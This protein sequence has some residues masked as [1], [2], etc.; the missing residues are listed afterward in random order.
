MALFRREMIG[1]GEL[2]RHVAVDQHPECRIGEQDVLRGEAVARDRRREVINRRAEQR[3]IG[4]RQL[5]RG[6]VERRRMVE[7][8]RRLAY[9]RG[10]EI[11]LGGILGGG[12]AG[13]E[14]QGEGGKR[15]TADH[16]RRLRRQR[17]A[18][19][20]CP[21]FARFASAILRSP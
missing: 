20:G 1:F 21:A 15:E 16:A 12:W 3:H 18:I 8:I 4:L 14:Q 6:I 2:R 17:Y 9:R 5:F 19:K 11:G 10:E 7:R 13:G